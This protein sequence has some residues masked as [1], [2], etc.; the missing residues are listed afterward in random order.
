MKTRYRY[1]ETP[2]GKILVAWSQDGL[3]GVYTG[4]QLAGQIDP[5]WQLDENLR[6][7]ATEQLQ[8]YFD[9]K[10]KHFDLPIVLNGTAF[11][12]R[13]WRRLAD[14]PYGRTASYGQIAASIGKPTASRAVGAANG[15]NPISIVLPCHRV[16]GA[17]GS[18]T[19][20]GGGLEVKQALLLHELKNAG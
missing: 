8:A 20:Y 5:A 18:L 12:E 1:M 13:V 17:D 19:G 15:Q 3:V 2:V 16:I 6:C 9:G 4:K 14:I 11:Q 10:L 7:A